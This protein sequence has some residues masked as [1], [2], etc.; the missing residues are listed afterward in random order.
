MSITDK[1]AIWLS[2]FSKKWM[3]WWRDRAQNMNI[4]DENTPEYKKSN[5]F[6]WM[7]SMIYVLLILQV[8]LGLVLTF[9][10]IPD[11]TPVDKV[12][13]GL[14]TYSHGHTYEMVMEEAEEIHH[15]FIEH[16]DFDSEHQ[17]EIFEVVGKKDFE[18]VVENLEIDSPVRD[19][20]GLI[21]L[22]KSHEKEYKK[23]TDEEQVACDENYLK[24]M[25]L[26]SEDADDLVAGTYHGET[27]ITEAIDEADVLRDHIIE[28]FSIYRLSED[29]TTLLSYGLPIAKIENGEKTTITIDDMIA[30]ADEAMLKESDTV[31]D[32]ERSI[33]QFAGKTKAEVID[34]TT[35]AGLPIPD[36]IEESQ[37][38]EPIFA[39]L[40]EEQ[41][42]KL[43][44]FA[45]GK[46]D[47]VKIAVEELTGL[48]GK[49]ADTI[50]E[51]LGVTVTRAYNSVA[52]ISK[53]PLTQWIRGIH[54]YGAYGIIALLML[55]WIRMFFCGE[56]KKPGELTWILLT[57]IVVLITFSGV[58]GYLLPFDQRAY[59][60]TTVGTQM[61][62]SLDSMPVIGQLGL[63]SA[64]K[65]MGL[66][67]H[68]VGQTT[69]LRFNII[70]YFLPILLFMMAEIYFIRSRKKRPKIN[71]IA[72]LL[73]VVVIVS[74]CLYLPAAN[75]PPPNT[76]KTPD[77]ILPDWYFLFVYFYLKFLPGY[78]GTLVTL[79]FIVFLVMFPLFD[80]RPERSA[81][82]RP[83]LITLAIGGLTFFLFGSLAAYWIPFQD[84]QRQLYINAILLFNAF[85]FIVAFL[86]YVWWRMRKSNKKKVLA[87]KLGIDPGLVEVRA[88]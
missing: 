13:P 38:L 47:A 69:I 23:M 35:Y 62:N 58:T 2:N 3:R 83:G 67:A 25:E 55:R 18:Y 76:V 8:C 34:G 41:K 43:H 52:E 14:V 82:G 79:L 86:L 42:E 6:Y 5:P 80:K 88:E 59:W 16:Y 60:A 49:S 26:A 71:W 10:Y 73:L 11:T 45:H 63:G 50:T 51:D 28:L 17:R 66:G 57:I 9:L 81:K 65:Y 27:Q 75:E 87:E 84:A 70:H 40:S 36:A 85:V 19:L 74:A 53:K 44:H 15:L 32:Y 7:G 46:D 29:S 4:L 22:G 12:E 31:T 56:F 68:Q 33:L 24:I 21:T 30:E 64:L 78:V 48:M 77:H 20:E 39:N 1:F 72:I 37:K 61:M 54:R